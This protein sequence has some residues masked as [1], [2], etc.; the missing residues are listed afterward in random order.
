MV[1]RPTLDQYEQ[2]LGLAIE[3]V[4]SLLA[5]VSALGAEKEHLCY[6]RDGLRKQLDRFRAKLDR[7]ALAK[8]AYEHMFPDRDG[9]EHETDEYLLYNYRDLADRYIKYLAG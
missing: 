6:E 9:W 4:E 5:E 3:Q 2:R 8:I 1:H 7:E